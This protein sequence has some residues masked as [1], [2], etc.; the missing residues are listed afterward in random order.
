MAPE[1][2]RLVGVAPSFESVD[3]LM[4]AL[5]QV[6]EFNAIEVQNVDIDPK[7]GGVRFTFSI[8]TVLQ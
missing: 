1:S 5:R 8:T 7:S 3:N 6:S 2:V 4:S